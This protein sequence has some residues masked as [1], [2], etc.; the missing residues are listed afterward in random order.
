MF[1]HILPWRRHRGIL[2]LEH[3]RFQLLDAPIL[4]C[5]LCAHCL[6]VSIRMCG[7]MHFS[8]RATSPL[9]ETFQPRSCLDQTLCFYQGKQLIWV[10][11]QP[12]TPATF[13]SHSA[14]KRA[15]PCQTHT[16]KAC[17]SD[18]PT[19]SS[20][21]RIW[22]RSLSA[23]ARVSVMSC[24]TRSSASSLCEQVWPFVRMLV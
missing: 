21:L 16:K 11:E 19:C 5:C 14:P 15:C 24:R 3:D 4:L 8:V 6:Q 1:T 22:L 23:S 13:T 17:V 9:L 2:E 20:V 7:M 10:C 18:K 12:W